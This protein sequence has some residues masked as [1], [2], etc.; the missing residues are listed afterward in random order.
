MSCSYLEAL[1]E[2]PLEPNLLDIL[3][4]PSA[5]ASALVYLLLSSDLLN[6][7]FSPVIAGDVRWA[8]DP[9]PS[10]CVRRRYLSLSLRRLPSS[11]ITRI[12]PLILTF[13][14]AVFTLFIR[15]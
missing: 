4:L 7:G 1:Y 12:H 15:E 3:E 6:F 13:F 5:M 14:S 9:S 10:S 2:T 8:T 11:Y